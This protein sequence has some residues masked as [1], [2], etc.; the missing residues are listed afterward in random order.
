MQAEALMIVVTDTQ[1]DK[2]SMLF[3]LNFDNAMKCWKEQDAVPHYQVSGIRPVTILDF[4]EFF[5]DTE[6]LE[7]TY[8]EGNVLRF[9]K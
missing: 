6:E 8:D 9:S 3:F 7:K 1:T 4:E 5:N 2:D